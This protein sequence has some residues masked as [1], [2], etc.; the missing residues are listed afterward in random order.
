MYRVFYGIRNKE[1]EVTNIVENL[2]R[3]SP[4][5]EASYNQLF[6]DPC[7]GKQKRLCIKAYYDI[8]LDEDSVIDRHLVYR[9]YNSFDWVTYVLN[10]DDLHPM[11][12]KEEALNHLEQYGKREN[13]FLFPL[14]SISGNLYLACKDKKT[15]ECYK[16]IAQYSGKTLIEGF[17]KQKAKLLKPEGN[18]I[19]VALTLRNYPSVLLVNPSCIE[20]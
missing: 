5:I 13:R 18:V 17:P 9:D 14:W 3:N 20:F 4:R 10:H 8:Y 2:L 11:R 16:K 6:G 7:P 1:I 15:V 12:T 19:D